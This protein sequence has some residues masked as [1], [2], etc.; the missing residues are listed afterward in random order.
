MIL[1]KVWTV[2]KDEGIGM[3][4]DKNEVQ[5]ILNELGNMFRSR[6]REFY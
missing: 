1:K 6:K 4:A 5:K 3:G 2:I